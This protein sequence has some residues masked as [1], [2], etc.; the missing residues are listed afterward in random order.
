MRVAGLELA[1]RHPSFLVTKKPPR[2]FQ[3]EEV[4]DLELGVT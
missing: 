1:R 4:S 3:A 2:P